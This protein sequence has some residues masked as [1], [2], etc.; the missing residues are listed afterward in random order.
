MTTLAASL[1]RSG[2]ARRFRF[3]ENG[4]TLARDSMAGLT[5]FIVMSYII[6]VNP[7]ILTSVPG[8]E[9]DAVLTS[10]CIVAGALT[11]IMGLY[12]NRAFAIAPGLGLNATVAFTLVAGEGITFPEAM[13]IVVLEGALV[14]ALVLFGWREAVME[15]IPLELKKAIAIGIG[16]F[17]A[18]IG[19]DASGLL[20]RAAEG[21]GPPVALVDFTSW[22]VAVVIFG[23]VVTIG[24]RAMGVRGDLLI[25]IILTTAFATILNYATDDGVYARETGWGWWPDNVF[26]GPDFSIMGD[27]SLDA[28]SAAKLGVIGAL[29]FVFTLFLADFFDTMGTLVGVGKQAG[30]LDKEGR[31]PQVR[32]PLLVDSVAAM[33]G[34]A[35]SASSATTYIESSAGVGVGGRTGWVSVIT[36][37]LFFPFLFLAPLIGMV[38]RAAT[39]PALL[40]VGWLMMT[41]LSEAEEEA[42]PHAAGEDRR[43]LAGINFGDVAIGLSAAVTIMLMPFSFSITDG[44]AAG[45]IVFVLIRIAQ[46]RVADVHPLMLGAAGLFVLYFLVPLLQDNFDWI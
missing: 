19:L 13:G 27:I 23:L 4:T 9:F 3:A 30:Y 24:M 5:T 16:L 26:Q 22:P 34:G 11:I 31:L 14:T 29:A 20:M 36:G 12:T 2:F 21:A 43:I 44:I 18:F 25:G 38:P 10:T 8:L 45:F 33:A 41:A 40:I 32:R 46:R 7:I 28:F 39:A 42:P 6:F 15:A 1:E 37:A 35:A 17:I